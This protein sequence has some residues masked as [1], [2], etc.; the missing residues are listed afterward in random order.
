MNRLVRDILKQIGYVA[1]EDGHAPAQATVNG[2]VAPFRLITPLR[3]KG[4]KTPLICFH[5]IGGGVSSYKRLTRALDDSIP[6]FGVHSRMLA[7]EDEHSTLAAMVSAYTDQLQ[8]FLPEGPYCLFG[9]SLGGFLA[10][11][12]AQRLE[13]AGRPVAFVGVA[14]CPDCTEMRAADARSRL[15]QL[16]AS[17]Y[18]QAAGE[19]TFLKPLDESHRASVPQLAGKLMQNPHD[20][21]DVLLAWLSE[22]GRLADSVPLQTIRAH[23]QRLTRHLLMVGSSSEKPVIRAPLFVWR[24]THG[25]GAE[26]DVWRRADNLPVSSALIEADHVTLMEAPAVEAIAR[27]INRAYAAEYCV[28]N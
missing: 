25:I 6:V 13:A 18:Q 20:G 16:I 21:P 27:Q 22:R 14:D 12:I 11:S 5:P 28:G 19:L 3:A 17:S 10:A 9:Y 15:A 26:T 24:A 2:R 4:S 7:G 23:L 1:D 8:V